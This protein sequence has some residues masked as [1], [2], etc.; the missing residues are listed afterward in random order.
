MTFDLKFIEYDAGIFLSLAFI[1][2]SFFNLFL[3]NGGVELC[4]L[5][6]FCLQFIVGLG[7]FVSVSVSTVNGMAWEGAFQRFISHKES[8][9]NNFSAI[10]LKHSPGIFYPIRP[11]CG[12]TSALFAFVP[13]DYM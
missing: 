8:K 13:I 9:F 1:D 3:L 7:K 5:R 11:W 4:C 12:E 6:L 10:K 2:L